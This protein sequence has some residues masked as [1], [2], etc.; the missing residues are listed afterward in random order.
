[1]HNIFLVQMPRDTPIAGVNTIGGKYGF[2]FTFP[3]LPNTYD[4]IL[5]VPRTFTHEVG[6]G[7]TLLHQNADTV[8][9]MAQSSV[10][11]EPIELS[12]RLRKEQWDQIHAALAA[13]PD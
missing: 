4:M 5:G 13:N 7:L 6:H 12:N 11:K 1:M 2:V 3:T 8:D 9:I 10:A